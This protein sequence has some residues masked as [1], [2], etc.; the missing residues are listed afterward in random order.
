MKTKFLQIVTLF[1][2]SL[3]AL[4]YW[5]NAQETL[6]NQFTSTITEEELRDHVYTLA[7]DSM[8]GRFTGEKGQKRAADYIAAEFDRSGVA[9]ITGEERFQEFRLEKC[10]WYL[11]QLSHRQKILNYPNDF[12]LLD[13]PLEGRKNLEAVFGGFGLMTDSYSDLAG[14]DVEG[15]VIIAFSGEPER[16]DGK[17]A[18]SGTDEVSRASRFWMKFRKARELGAAG[19]I[20]LAEKDRDFNKYQKQYQE[21]RKRRGIDYPDT[22]DTVDFFGLYTTTGN[23]AILLDVDEKELLRAHEGLG[24]EQGSEILGK[25]E[26][27]TLN[28]RKNCSYIN[29]ENVAG[30]VEGSGRK[31]EYIVVVAHY[32]HLGKDG[33][34][35]YSGADD[36][37][38]GTAAV[39]E[40]AEAFENAADEGFRPQR[41]VIFLLVSAEELGLY[42]SRYFTENSPVPL[43]K[44]YAVLNIDMI[45]RYTDRFK[46]DT[47]YIWGWG[48]RSK[49]IVEV[50]RQQT[51]VT[52]PGLDFKITYSDRRGGGSD[53][54]YFVKEGIPG[55]FFFT[56]THKDYHQTGD[57]PKKLL[58][59]RMEKI[60]RSI[61][62]TAY[63]LANREQ[64]LVIEEE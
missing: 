58:Y 17:Y 4:P 43:D 53:H 33:R 36:N 23:A 40:I 22:K 63:H 1:T 46:D 11:G 54:Y 15:K 59:G 7:A 42:G 12:V 48:Y 10:T 32:D 3:A 27:I 19:M 6:V 41:S 26:N 31:D 45:G 5:A 56:G 9:T 24:K 35:V 62:A 25:E 49:E 38:S 50:A 57:V 55:I 34:K 2:I 47:D 16:E 61:F 37:A 28:F 52:A 18:V 14:L 44:I 20:L 51:S 30:F 39:M 8:E 60:V 64:P 13:E 29:T 21:N